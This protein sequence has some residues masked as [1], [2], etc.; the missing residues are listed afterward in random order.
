MTR[1][2]VGIDL[3]DWDLLGSALA[4]HLEVD[5]TSWGGG[6]D[7]SLFTTPKTMRGGEWVDGVRSS[8]GAFKATHHLLGNSL[9]EQGADTA[10]CTMHVQA[11]HYLP[12]DRGD[13][14]FTLGGYYDNRLRRDPIGEWKIERLKLV[15]L[16]CRGNRFVFELAYQAGV[17]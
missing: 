11:H 13:N 3:H 9:V 8:M 10:R 1:Y 14:E 17:R 12:N 16:W 6:R 5:F 2:A 4:E 7:L 15:V